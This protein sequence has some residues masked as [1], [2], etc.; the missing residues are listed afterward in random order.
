[1]T[2]KRL[3]YKLKIFT[4]SVLIHIGISIFISL[5]YSQL[6]DSRINNQKFVS[7]NFDEIKNGN[8]VP[9][10]SSDLQNS[11]NEN[12]KNSSAT[13]ENE[14]YGF[15]FDSLFQNADSTELS[16]IY[17]DETRGVRIKYPTGWIYLDQKLNN[18]FD[19]VTFWYQGT[20]IENPAYIHLEISEKEFFF[21]NKYES[22]FITN[23]LTWYYNKPEIIGDYVNFEIYLR[24][25]K[26]VDFIIKLSVKRIEDFYKFQPKFLGMVKSLKFQ[27]DLFKILN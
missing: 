6:L 14:R 26:D 11:E 18:K 22:K 16:E 4:F 25:D 2:I 9:I 15:V 7:I 24:T 23:E 12:I 1:M 20:E 19:G 5:L 21:E 13:S 3:S 8:T 10:K 27:S 17:Y